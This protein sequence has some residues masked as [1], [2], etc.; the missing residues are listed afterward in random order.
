MA[1][2]C[3]DKVAVGDY[4][5]R[6]IGNVYLVERLGRYDSLDVVPFA[7]LPDQFV[8]RASH[9]SGSTIIVTDKRALLASPERLNR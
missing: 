5:A 6:T 8:I 4:V 9:D 2:Q 1:R 3:A 7:A